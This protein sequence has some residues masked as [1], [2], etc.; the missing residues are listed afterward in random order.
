MRDP[1]KYHDYIE[2][3]EFSRLLEK[4]SRGVAP[5]PEDPDWIFAIYIDTEDYEHIASLFEAASHADRIGQREV[6]WFYLVE[7]ALEMGRHRGI[8]DA[9]FR[10]SPEQGV[11]S[12][13]RKNGMA[14]GNAKGRNAENKRNEAA[15]ALI[16][17]APNGKWPSKAAF[18]LKYHAIVKSVPGFSNTDHQRRLLMQRSDIRATLPVSAKRAAAKN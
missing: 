17:V 8:R 14:G 16:D 12:L 13:L 5:L 1:N 7:A 6:A 18:D 15:K 4:L 9:N 10:N 3:K 11:A 2:P